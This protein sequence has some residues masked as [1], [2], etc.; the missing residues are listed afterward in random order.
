M[1][2]EQP[3]PKTPG[4]EIPRHLEAD[5]VSPITHRP[6]LEH[7]ARERDHALES[8]EGLRRH[9][10]TH[11]AGDYSPS[12]YSEDGAGEMISGLEVVDPTSGKGPVRSLTG[13]TGKGRSSRGE[14]RWI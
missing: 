9:G 13:N 3:R 14:S 12:L 8:L 10:K 6:S 11:S 7:V 1:P 4:Q 5:Q 2:P